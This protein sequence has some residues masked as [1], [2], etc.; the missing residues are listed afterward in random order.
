MRSR[1]RNR[2]RDRGGKPIRLAWRGH[3][4]RSFRRD[5]GRYLQKKI[6]ATN[7]KQFWRLS[8]APPHPGEHPLPGA[9]ITLRN[10]ARIIDKTWP[11]DD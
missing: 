5:R 10:G 11:A 6:A 2:T 8:L 7:L 3:C 1:F 4:P 9:K